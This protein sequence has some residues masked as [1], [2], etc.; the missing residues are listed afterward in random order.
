MVHRLRAHKL[1]LEL[2]NQ[3]LREAGQQLEHHLKRYTDLYD[4]APVGY[5]ALAPDGTIQEINLAGAALL[6]WNAPT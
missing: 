5:A 4:F 3:A 1:Q 6:A 2:Q